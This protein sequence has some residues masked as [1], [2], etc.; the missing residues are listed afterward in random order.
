MAYFCT[1]F[2]ADDVKAIQ[3]APQVKKID[4]YGLV[5]EQEYNELM[6]EIYA[7]GNK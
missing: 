2:D 3:A 4:I 7:E 1:N 5:S 6:K